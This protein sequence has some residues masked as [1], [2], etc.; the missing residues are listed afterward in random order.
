M[1]QQIGR[2]RG[3]RPLPAI[4][5]GAAGGVVRGGEQRMIP[6]PPAPLGPREAAVLTFTC[7]VIVALVA[8]GVS[9][10][11]A[12]AAATSAALAMARLLRIV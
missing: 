2:G 9:P 10:Y 12:V 4:M 3:R 8:L 11:M 6:Q 5:R 7:V 1:V